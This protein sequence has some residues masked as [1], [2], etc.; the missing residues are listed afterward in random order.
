VVYLDGKLIGS[1][2]DKSYNDLPAIVD[3]LRAKHQ[4]AEVEAHCLGEDCAGRTHRWKIDV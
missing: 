4:H 1:Y 3:E 2:F